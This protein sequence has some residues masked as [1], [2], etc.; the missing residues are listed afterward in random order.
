M[1]HWQVFIIVVIIISFIMLIYV[2]FKPQQNSND[3]KSDTF[4]NTMSNNVNQI[5]LKSFDK[6]PII[7]K[8]KFPTTY[9]N[10]YYNK[11]LPLNVC[12]FY[13]A[14]SYKSYLP[15]GS[16][17]STYSYNAIK[18]CLLKGARLINLDI[19]DK[20]IFENNKLKKIIAVVRDKVPNPLAT[21]PELDLEKCFQII[22]KYAW[23]NTPSDYPLILHLNLN[24]DNIS[25][26][27][28]IKKKLVKVFNGKFINKIYSFAGR[29]DQF[30]FGQIPIT[31][32]LGKVAIITNKMATTNAGAL[33]EFINGTVAPNQKYISE[34]AYTPNLENYGGLISVNNSIGDLINNNKTNLTLVVPKSDKETNLITPYECVF[35]KNFMLRGDPKSDLY[36]IN[37]EDCWKFGCQFVL[38]NYQLYD[39][40]MKKYIEK[41]KN[42]GLILKP[43]NLRSIPKPTE[44]TNKQNKEASYAPREIGVKGWYSYNI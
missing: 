40:N 22:K 14:S 28:D 32:L 20:A 33:N 7:N 13:W 4:L 35:N 8:N 9:F 44:K 18:E 37:P 2:L 36:N 17:C 5:C 34:I 3:K 10:K 12:D 23:Y 21:D 42:S 29:G 41:F 1:N 30:P 27:L 39:D 16:V 24:T 38:M 11:N 6:Y 26:Q 19:Y 31:E 25:A 43:E 15:C